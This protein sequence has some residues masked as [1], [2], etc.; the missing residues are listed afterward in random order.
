MNFSSWV[1]ASNL[2]IISSP[3]ADQE[4]VTGGGGGGGIKYTPED[5]IQCCQIDLSKNPLIF[6]VTP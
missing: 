5:D 1:N 6:T 4:F 2:A 3:M